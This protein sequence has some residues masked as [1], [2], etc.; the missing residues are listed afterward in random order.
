M[1]IKDEPGALE[2]DLVVVVHFQRDA[3]GLEGVGRDESVGVDLQ[4]HDRVIR[5]INS[6]WITA[7]SV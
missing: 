4:T 2:D 6:A 5:H 7:N 3:Q 1:V